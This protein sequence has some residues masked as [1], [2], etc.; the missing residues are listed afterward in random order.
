M[1][2]FAAQ[3]THWQEVC[4]LSGALLLPRSLSTSTWGGREIALRVLMCEMYVSREGWQA[5]CQWRSSV[6][7]PSTMLVVSRVC[8]TVSIGAC[9]AMETMT[10]R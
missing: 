7:V 1:L 10:L 3:I 5:M 4:G 9:R 6:E 8:C 2:Q